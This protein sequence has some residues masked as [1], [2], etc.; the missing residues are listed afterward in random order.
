MSR[1]LDVFH[2]DKKASNLEDLL[3]RADGGD[4]SQGSTGGGRSKAAAC[5]RLRALLTKDPQEI[6]RSIEGLMAEDFLLSQSGPEQ[7]DV[8]CTVRG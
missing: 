4:A 8:R 6:S 2:W 1:I 7:E 3:D 5:N